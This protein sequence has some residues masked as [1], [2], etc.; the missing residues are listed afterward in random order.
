VAR[1]EHAPDAAAAVFTGACEWAHELIHGLPRRTT[2]PQ[3]Y[4]LFYRVHGTLEPRRNALLL[5]L[6][7]SL[8]DFPEKCGCESGA[9]DW[10]F[11]RVYRTILVTQPYHKDL[12]DAVSDIRQPVEG[13]S[14]H[15]DWMRRKYA[16]S[17]RNARR[18]SI[19]RTLVRDAAREDA[20]LQHVINA[21]RALDA[22][23]QA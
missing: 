9:G 3:V 8:P 6:H 19:E 23:T 13:A 7:R 22:L 1:S 20:A 15:D 11:A 14:R 18:E 5:E 12:D 21:Q 2:F 10:Y 17:K 16:E 4:N